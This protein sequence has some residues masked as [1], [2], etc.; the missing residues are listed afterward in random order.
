MGDRAPQLVPDDPRHQVR[1][2]LALLVQQLLALLLL[3]DEELDDA[4]GGP[5]VPL[6][7]DE[8]MLEQFAVGQELG[9]ARPPSPGPRELREPGARRCGPGV[10]RRTPGDGCGV[11]FVSPGRSHVGPSDLTWLERLLRRLL[12]PLALVRPRLLRSPRSGGRRD[13]GN[14]VV[15][16]DGGGLD[17]LA[18]RACALLLAPDAGLDVRGQAPSPDAG[19][20][21]CLLALG[22]RRR[23]LPRAEAALKFLRLAPVALGPVGLVSPYPEPRTPAVL[24]RE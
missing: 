2:D 22:A 8:Q 1:Q 24:T 6:N 7:C 10:R 4:A 3:V 16:D 12:L 13:L 17:L 18:S 9:V 14:L 5:P 11:R 23:A 20:S 21:A 15:V 19:P